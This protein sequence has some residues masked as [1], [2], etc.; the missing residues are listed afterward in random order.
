MRLQLPILQTNSLNKA[1]T[2]IERLIADKHDLEAQCSIRKKKL[3]ADFEFIRDN[4]F[5]ILLSG[6]STILSSYLRSRKKSKEQTLA[7]AKGNQPR[8]LS[9]SNWMTVVHALTPLVWNIVKPLIVR[10]GINKAK[11]FLVSLFT[12]KKDDTPTDIKK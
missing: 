3:Y 8:P 1:P 4:S 12:D 7:L 10:W 9:S 6:L 11:A 5:S 2:P